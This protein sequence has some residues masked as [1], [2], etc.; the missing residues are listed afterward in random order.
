MANESTEQL[1]FVKASDIK[2]LRWREMAL[3]V[4]AIFY[5]I[6]T[7][8]PDFDEI[9]KKPVPY[10]LKGKNRWVGDLM[11]FIWNKSD[12]DCYAHLAA[13]EAVKD[14][15]EHDQLAMK[16]FIDALEI[17]RNIDELGEVGDSACRYFSE[18]EA[19]TYKI[20]AIVDV[21]R[22]FLID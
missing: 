8:S 3:E 14:N 19:F 18:D 5:N 17:A 2:D 1:S 4:S 6:L 15:T 13:A 7:E 16:L 11:D 9:I 12:R 22:D 20:N 10:R 21:R